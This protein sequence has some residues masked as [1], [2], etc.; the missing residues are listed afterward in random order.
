MRFNEDDVYRHLN[1]RYIFYVYSVTHSLTRTLLNVISA[2]DIPFVYF[3][4]IIWPG[5]RGG[6]H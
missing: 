4:V 5:R 6:V 3:A 2:K 1:L